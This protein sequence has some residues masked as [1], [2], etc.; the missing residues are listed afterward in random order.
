M[1]GS[2]RWG[3][4]GEDKASTTGSQAVERAAVGVWEAAGDSPPS[5]A[6]RVASTR[7]EAG[8]AMGCPVSRPWDEEVLKSMPWGRGLEGMR[9]RGG[10]SKWESGRKRILPA[11]FVRLSN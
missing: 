2:S 9:G 11:Y 5:T 1:K 8:A 4:R 6:M 10:A 7:R 3:V